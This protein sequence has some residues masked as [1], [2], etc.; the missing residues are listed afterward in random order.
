[1][2]RPRIHN[3]ATERQAARRKRLK[4]LSR[5]NNNV[6]RLMEL[7]VPTD[8]TAQHSFMPV[9]GDMPDLPEA[10]RD[11]SY[12]PEKFIIAARQTLGWIDLD[13][14]SSRLAQATIMAYHWCGL[15]HPQPDRRDGLTVPW[16]GR[17]WVNPPFSG[18]YLLRYTKRLLA[19]YHEG[20]VTAACLLTICDST[21]EYSHLLLTH[22]TAFCWP[23]D[24]IN[25]IRPALIDTNGNP[26]SHVIWYIGREVKR[27]RSAFSS[28]GTIR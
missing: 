9:A 4:E 20:D 26:G 11:D 23:H 28:H 18:G 5:N 17:L 14:A 27:F 15:D 21:T 22:A 6:T 25:F 24:R 2:G 10:N 19:A 1:M 8:R 7:P 3:N 16:A 13:P 12:T